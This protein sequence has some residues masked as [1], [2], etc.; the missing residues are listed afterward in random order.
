MKQQDMD[1]FLESIGGL[2]EMRWQEPH[3]ITSSAYMDIGEGWYPLVKKLIED[4][5]AAGWDKEICQIKEKFGGLRF[6]VRKSS[7]E[8]NMLIRDA[9]RASYT[10]C[11]RTGKPGELRR[12]I[13][14]WQTLCEAE[15]IKTK[16][17]QL[18]G[19]E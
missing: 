3:I 11:E 10:I 16:G 15:Y 6:Y 5:L 4:L 18:P 19:Y 17:I 1:R 2:I 7:D 14:W 13:G 9:E 12:D 8:I